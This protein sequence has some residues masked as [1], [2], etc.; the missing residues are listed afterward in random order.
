MSALSPHFALAA[1]AT[2]GRLIVTAHGRLV[3]GHGAD[4][5]RWRACLGQDDAG[6]VL[7]DLGGVTALD[8]GGVGVLAS[9]VG[10]VTGRGGRVRVVT[11]SP[12]A[13]RVLT[14]SGLGSILAST[15]RPTWRSPAA[16]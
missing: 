13:E 2:P 15:R 3:T 4:A 8:A 12:R 1:T 7:V 16:A 9:L 6:D 14:M 10:R 5:G 11:A